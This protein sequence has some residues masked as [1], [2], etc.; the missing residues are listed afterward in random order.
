MK[1][2]GSELIAFLAEAWPTPADSW[3][4]DHDL[5]EEPD[6]DTIYETSDIGGIY[7]QGSGEDPTKGEGYDLGSLIRKWRKGRAYDVLTVTVPRAQTVTI[8]A[9]IEALGVKVA[10]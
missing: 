9:A 10:T 1:I 8:K 6:P 5:F 2:K 7:F 3:F 4:W